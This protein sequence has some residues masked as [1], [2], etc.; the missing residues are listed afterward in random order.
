MAKMQDAAERAAE[1]GRDLEAMRK[2]AMKWTKCGKSFGDALERWK[3]R[4]S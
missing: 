2:P 1:G 3:W 4:S